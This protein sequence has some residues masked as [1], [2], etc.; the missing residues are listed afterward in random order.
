MVALFEV[1]NEVAKT[2]IDKS[3]CLTAYLAATLLAIGF[4]AYAKRL[5][6]QEKHMDYRALA[7]GLRVQFFWKLASLPDEAAD[8]YLRK[9]CGELEWIRKTIQNWNLHQPQDGSAE[10]TSALKDAEKREW[11]HEHWVRDQAAFFKKKVKEKQNKCSGYKQ[12][13]KVF[14]VGSLVIL[15]VLLASG[16][17]CPPALTEELPRRSA[18]SR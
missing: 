8:H 12:K 13:M 9:H 18:A 7:E 1:F 17:A 14:F 4:F 15:F 2:S 3:A 5:R 11:V 10:E 16:P 6:F